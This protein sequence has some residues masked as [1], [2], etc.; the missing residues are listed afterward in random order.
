MLLKKTSLL[1]FAL[2]LSLIVPLTACGG[3]S[4]LEPS[5]T[6]SRPETSSPAE[7]HEDVSY[8]NSG[9]TLTIPAEAA[10]LVLVIRRRMIRTACCSV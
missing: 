4:S 6:V 9:L 5:Q 8:V 1:C 3:K 7:Q 2:A 10:N